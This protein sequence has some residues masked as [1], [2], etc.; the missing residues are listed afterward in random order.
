[1]RRV[2]PGAG[3]ACATQL[4]ALPG[5]QFRNSANQVVIQHR[6]DLDGDFS[7]DYVTERVKS[8]IDGYGRG[9]GGSGNTEPRI[10]WF[11]W[12]TYQ[13]PHWPLQAPSE[14]ADMYVDVAGSGT[15]GSARKFVLAL[16]KHM[17]DSVGAILQVGGRLVLLQKWDQPG[18]AST[19]GTRQTGGGIYLTGCS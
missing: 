5:S 13:N 15:S 9:G 7:T 2:T 14:Y 16:T 8:L 10:P 18:R 6:T 4:H 3:H 19:D 12:V 1:M 11:I 17:D